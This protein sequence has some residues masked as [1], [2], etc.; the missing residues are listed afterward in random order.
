ME[1]GTT[2]MLLTYI[3]PLRHAH[4]SKQT[5]QRKMTMT[6]GVWKVVFPYVF[7]I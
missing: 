5:E 6:D 3:K 2:S 4:K 7:S 1:E